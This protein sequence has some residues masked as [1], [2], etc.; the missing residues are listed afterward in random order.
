MKALLQRVLE[1]YVSVDE[2]E[3]SRIGEGMLILLGVEK[4]DGPAEAKYL[5]E[6]CGGLRFFRD[7]EGKMN[8]S[9]VDVKGEALV[10]SQEVDV[11]EIVDDVVDAV[12]EGVLKIGGKVIFMRPD[13]LKKQKRIALIPSGAGRAG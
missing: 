9:V 12:I 5:A 8:L 2:K 7:D 6:K 3:V 1:A 4:G 11:R 10:V 13:S